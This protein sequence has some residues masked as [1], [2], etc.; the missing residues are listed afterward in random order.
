MINQKA[1]ESLQEQSHDLPKTEVIYQSDIVLGKS[2]HLGVG[3][4]QPKMSP[5]YSTELT[6]KAA[7]ATIP[8]V[9]LKIG[10]SV[11]DQSQRIKSN[12]S[13]DI[14]SKFNLSMKGPIG[15][16]TMGFVGK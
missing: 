9:Q 13:E 16:I 12:F 15:M 1:Y 11:I 3:K 7:D 8:G 6:L 4:C 5:F 2:Y 14:Q 10:S